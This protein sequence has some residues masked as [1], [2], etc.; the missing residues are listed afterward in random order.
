MTKWRW[1]TGKDEDEGTDENKTDDEDNN[2][3][4]DDNNSQDGS[5]MDMN[6]YGDLQIYC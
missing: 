5:D 4:D 3:E 6:W 2:E 1:R